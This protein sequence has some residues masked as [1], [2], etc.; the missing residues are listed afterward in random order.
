MR[1]NET[2]RGGKE[3]EEEGHRRGERRAGG[4]GRGGEAEPGLEGW[5]WGEKEQINEEEIVLMCT[6]EG[7]GCHE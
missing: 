5:R 1:N 7:D 2:E 6:E 3:G 4:S